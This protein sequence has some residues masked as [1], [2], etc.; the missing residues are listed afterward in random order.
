DPQ[1]R[2]VPMA[3]SG[4]RRLWALA[5]PVSISTSTVT[6]LTLVNLFW[7]G[8]LGTVAVAAV[9]L[10]GQIL[11]I[12]FGVSNIVYGGVLAIVARRVGEGDVEKAFTASVHGICLGALLGVVVGLLG[13]DSAPAVLGFFETGHDV[14]A[15]AISYLRIMYLGQ[16]PLFVS[17]ALG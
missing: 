4:Y 9:S 14:E 8:H 17:V 7:I 5:W 3:P 2:A 12:V 1:Q 11:F 16:L 13:I 10:C 6:L 15:Q